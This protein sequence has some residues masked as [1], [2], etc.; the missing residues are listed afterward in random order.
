VVKYNGAF[1]MSGN[2]APLYKAPNILGPYEVLGPWKNEKGEPWTITF[3]GRTA[4]GAFDVDMFV[5]DDNKPYFR[6][7]R[8]RI[9]SDQ[10]PTRR[11]RSEHLFLSILRMYGA[12]G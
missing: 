6:D 9:A 8:G 7:D 10:G 5:D 3:N 4:N 11:R 12:L 2:D 1:Y